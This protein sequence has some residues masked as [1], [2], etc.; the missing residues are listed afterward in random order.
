MTVVQME[1]KGSLNVR[2]VPLIPMRD[3]VM[4]RG[5]YDTLTCRTFYENTSYRD[6]Y[7]HITLTDEE[8][9][10]NALGNLRIIYRNLMKLEYDN[11]RTRTNA[12][13]SL[14]EQP[15]EKS[16][17]DL[18]EDFYRQQNN[19]PLSEEQATYLE[20]MIEMIWEDPS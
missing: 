9:I 18:F 14:T 19:T 4:L 8:D 10:P 16:P 20:K 3:L 1:K 15:A 7:V 12:L 11:R 6:D 2:T 13:L 17:Y 5:A